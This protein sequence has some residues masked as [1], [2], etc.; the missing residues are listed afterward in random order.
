MARR[1]GVPILGMALLL[2]GG[3]DVFAQPGDLNRHLLNRAPIRFPVEMSAR[4]RAAMIA[5][6]PPRLQRFV[7]GPMRWHWT[8]D[9]GSSLQRTGGV[10]RLVE[11]SCLDAFCHKVDCH[12]AGWPAFYCED[13]VTRQMSAPDGA[14]V[15]FADKVFQRTW[16][17]ASA[18]PRAAAVQ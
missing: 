2:A 1:T 7:S 5:L 17:A 11:G 15:T 10:F 6:D 4:Y 8:A 16:P 3:A 18:T 14:R 12:P 9:D 13:D